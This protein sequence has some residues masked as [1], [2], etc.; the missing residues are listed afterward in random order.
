MML[1]GRIAS[2]DY[3]LI[4]LDLSGFL[5]IQRLS[6]CHPLGGNGEAAASGTVSK[7]TGERRSGGGYD[8]AEILSPGAA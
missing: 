7:P 1:D 3:D 2:C 5:H 4:D 8:A 6:C